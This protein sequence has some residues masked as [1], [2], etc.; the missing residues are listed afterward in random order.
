MKLK[1]LLLSLLFAFTALTSTVQASVHEAP[2]AP[3]QE[4]EKAYEPKSVTQLLVSFFETTGL[5]AMVNPQD[6]VKNGHGEE[7]IEPIRCIDTKVSLLF[8]D[9]N[10]RH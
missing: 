7:I 4:A 9:P 2:A 6:G 10:R 8:P 5:S 1:H 3:A